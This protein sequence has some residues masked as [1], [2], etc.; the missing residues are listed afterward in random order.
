ML[1][2]PCG[3]LFTVA[4]LWQKVTE[5]TKPDKRFHEKVI[6]RDAGLPLVQKNGIERI[7]LL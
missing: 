6:E 3:I 5:G 2:I 4:Q 7:Y 1:V